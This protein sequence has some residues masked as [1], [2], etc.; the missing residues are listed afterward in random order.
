[1]D[2]VSPERR[3]EIMGRVA[4]ENTGPEIAVRRLL[5]RLGYRFR[6]HRKNLPGKP[7]VV[8]PKWRTVVLIH[9][10][11]WHRHDGC[12]NTRTPKSKVEFW[13]R[14]FAE[15]VERDR[16][17]KAQLESLGWRVLVIWECE[18]KDV[19]ALAERVEHFIKESPC[20]QSNSSQARAD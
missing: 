19:E 8:L 4:G 15:N 10:C 18:L 20:D 17:A 2:S 14:K 7:D 3:S 6:L 16:K 13:T 9:G 11:F 12:P 5:H 1:M